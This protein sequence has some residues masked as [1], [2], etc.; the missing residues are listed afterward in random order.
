MA[1]A[2]SG[3]HT[4]KTSCF[5]TSW[6]VLFHFV[7]FSGNSLNMIIPCEIF[8]NRYTKMLS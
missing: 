3:N 6:T 4:V 2:Y 7:C 8:I 1:E 5:N